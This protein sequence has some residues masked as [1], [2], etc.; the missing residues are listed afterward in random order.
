[1]NELK[2]TDYKYLL[3]LSYFLFSKVKSCILGSRQQLCINKGARATAKNSAA[4]L[5]AVCDSMCK[6]HSCRYNR[7]SL[8]GDNNKD[9]GIS[10][11]DIGIKTVC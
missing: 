4:I 1:M 10:N 8:Y 3:C 9:A 7:E 11:M 5:N 2:K 6:A